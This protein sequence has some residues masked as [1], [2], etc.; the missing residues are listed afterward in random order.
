[1]KKVKTTLWIEGVQL[2]EIDG[3]HY[4]P[5]TVCM[6]DEGK[7]VGIQAASKVGKIVNTNFKV[8]LGDYKR[9]VTSSKK[10]FPTESGK[11]VSAFELS[12]D[13]FDGVLKKVESRI[14][15]NSPE[16]WKV[17][18]KI[19]VAEPLAFQ[20][21]GRDKNWIGNYRDNIRNILNRYDVVEF[22]PEP[23]AVYQYYRYGLR[24]PQLNDHVKHVALIV[25]FGGGTFDVC[26]IES[27][28]TGDV[29]MAGKHSKPLSAA[30]CPVGGF[31]I[32]KIIAEYLVCRDLE[33]DGEKK[34]AGQFIKVFERVS[35]GELDV[36]T[37][38]DEKQAFV[39]NL[40]R[41]ITEIEPYKKKL[42]EM[43]GGW[44]LAGECYEKVSMLMPKNP[45]S[46]DL[47]WIGCDF[48]GHE[49]RR[50][51]IDKIWNIHLK[52]IVSQVL[53]RAKG[54]LRKKS[55]TTTLLSGG[56]S[57]MKW[58]EKLLVRDFSEELADA[59]PLPLGHS[60]QEIVAKGL[61]IECA[62][63]YYDPASEFVSVTYNP[64]KL[65]LSPDGKREEAKNFRP[66]QNKV[67]MSGANAGDLI[68][69]AQSLRQFID[70][71]VQWKVKLSSEPRHY[72]KYNFLR[73]DGND[74][75]SDAYNIGN[76]LV[77]SKKNGA[78]DSFVKVELTMRLDGT[79]TPRFIYKTG[80]VDFGIPE[81]IVDGT[82]FAIDMT[83]ITVDNVDSNKF[84]G[85][86]FG[87]S[88]SSICEVSSQ[89]IDT[90]EQRA[91]E[92]SWVSLKEAL[93]MMPYPIASP[94]RNYLS[95]NS[96]SESDTTAQARDVFEACLAFM[97]YTAASEAAANGVL[98]KALK[99][100]QHRSMG[101]LRELLD[102]SLSRLGDKAIFSRE[103]KSLTKT[104]KQE[105]DKAI[106]EFTNHKHDKL[107]ASKVSSHEHLMMVVN[108]VRES[109]REKE[110][111][112]FSQMTV[113]KF[114]KGVYKGVFVVAH[115]LQP[116]VEKLKYVGSEEFRSDECLL[117]DK[118]TGA[119]LNYFPLFIWDERE[120]TSNPY[121]CY[122]YDKYEEGGAVL[123]EADNKVVISSSEI[124]VDLSLLYSEFRE[125]GKG[126]D[127]VQIL[128]SP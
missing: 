91:H 102:V 30:S 128:L 73:P 65:H 47:D 28:E 13:F 77:Q 50:I 24:I 69:S 6:D 90:I 106:E 26:V 18:A 4:I 71:P 61:A 104:H 36:L 48:R 86:D 115:D 103:F 74:D 108:I 11:S 32:N 2:S 21:K 89:N 31:Y 42:V 64:I 114:K 83:A 123:K 58:L 17:H 45:F 25:D 75:S 8:E 85:L 55:I 38:N 35:S 125:Q 101:P 23:F 5:T 51:Y 14:E 56:S 34:K 99:N 120:S 53:V 70:D 116:F 19:M 3:E 10:K 94:L 57:N 46:A 54:E 95:V 81:H 126:M 109:M 52:K 96:V 60:F 97:A 98:K 33:R 41:L 107:I 124:S 22:L 20:V 1:M 59:K 44:E 63:R 72:L 37:L 79:V 15:K 43:I 68:A 100:Y 76:N 39:S 29:S 84:I 112:F 122:V 121:C 27:T 110:F 105:L 119:L 62:R 9:N 87:T 117:Y 40:N 118:E 127:I 66:V 80:N 67:D 12:R 92:K 16:D 111:G 88:S 78:F 7:S 93:A 82:P 49:L 113:E